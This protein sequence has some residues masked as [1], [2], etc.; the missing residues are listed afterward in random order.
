MGLTPAA[1]SASRPALALASATAFAAGLAATP[2]I[3][4][5]T[6]FARG[7]SLA[8]A[9]ATASGVGVARAS[10]CGGLRSGTGIG[11]RRDR[12]RATAVMD[13]VGVIIE[14]GDGKQRPWVAAL[15]LVSNVGLTTLQFTWA[16][17]IMKQLTGDKKPDDVKKD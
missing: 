15:F 10:A 6:R 11:G 12:A 5:G 8:A 1:T 17:A 16:G 13:V 4:L 7:V 3:G 9:F 2:A 14:G